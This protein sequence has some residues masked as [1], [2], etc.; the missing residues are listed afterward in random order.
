M[1]NQDL[2]QPVLGWKV[3]CQGGSVYTSNPESIPDTVQ[4]VMYYHDY[5]Y[6]TIE[7]G[8]DEY[9]VDGYTLYG[10]EIDINQYEEIL[11]KVI[12]DMEWP[13]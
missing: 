1:Y 9:I 3:F 11:D 10:K 7:H 4:A 5:P 6:R 8:V 12:K 2:R 13:S